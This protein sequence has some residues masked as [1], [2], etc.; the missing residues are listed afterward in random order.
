MIDPTAQTPLKDTG[1]ETTRLKGTKWDG[2]IDI[3]Y[4]SATGKLHIQHHLIII[5][6]LEQTIRL[7]RKINF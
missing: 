2:N 6:Q 7:N 4:T 3:T 5:L 1:L